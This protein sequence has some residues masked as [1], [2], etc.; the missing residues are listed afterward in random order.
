MGNKL[1]VV[2]KCRGLVCRKWG[3]AAVLGIIN[4]PPAKFFTVGYR[5]VGHTS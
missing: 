4:S 3:G 1:E 2:S 5:A